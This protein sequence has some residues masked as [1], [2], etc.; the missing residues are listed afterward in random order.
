MQFCLRNGENTDISA[1]PGL[2]KPETRENTKQYNLAKTKE[3]EEKFEISSPLQ[4]PLYPF[5]KFTKTTSIPVI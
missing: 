5:F 2:W 1:S 4:I 3:E